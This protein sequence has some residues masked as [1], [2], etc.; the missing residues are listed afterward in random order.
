MI[1]KKKAKAFTLSE[2]VVTIVI[3]MIVVGM[4]FSVLRMV[5]KEMN[6][7]QKELSEKTSKERLELALWIDFNS[8]PS[9]SYDKG[10]EKLTLRNQSDSIIYFFQQEYALRDNRD[11]F[12]LK[13]AKKHLYRSGDE[14]IDGKI[15]A[16]GK[17]VQ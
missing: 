17:C 2:V 10:K 9:I 4:A 5:Q 14:V 8:L 1:F 11:T 12:Y 7:A 6:S 13:I 16:N 3:T 15:D